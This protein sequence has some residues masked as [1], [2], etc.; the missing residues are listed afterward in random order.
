MAR[1]V[2]VLVLL[3]VALGVIACATAF[4]ASAAPVDGA[5]AAALA[6]V[7]PGAGSTQAA[8]VTC[9]VRVARLQIRTGPG[10][11]F[12]PIGQLTQSSVFTAVSFAS[13]GIPSGQWVEAQLTPGRTLGFVAANAQFIFCQRSLTGL[14]VARIPATPRPGVTRAPSATPTPVDE[15]D[16]LPTNGSSDQESSIKGRGAPEG[17]GSIV[18]PGVKRGEAQ[19]QVDENGFFAFGDRLVFKVDPY[20]ERV[21][22]KPGDGIKEVQFTLRYTDDDGNE[23][24]AHEKTEIRAPYCVFGDSGTGPCAVWRF[25]QHGNRFPSGAPVIIDRDIFADITIV[26]VQGDSVSWFWSFRLE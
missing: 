9:V 11:V 26:P 15:G 24:I 16:L 2:A 13:R 18:L 3:V 4:N 12:P 23:V 19:R 25:S 6:A 17:L 20:D 8:G 21:G 5:S 22:P 1:V 7:P 14:P 10:T